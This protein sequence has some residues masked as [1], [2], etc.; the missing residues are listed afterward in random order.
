MDLD[1]KQN[2][3]A[4]IS[5][6][7]DLKNDK[8]FVIKSD[9]NKTYN[10]IAWA[11]GYDCV[12]VDHTGNPGTWWP[13]NVEKSSN[14]DALVKAFKEVGFEM[15]DDCT[16]EQDFDKVILYKKYNVGLNEDEWTHASRVL[17]NDV[18]YSKFG[19]QWDGTHSHGVLDNTTKSGERNSYG[20]PYAYMKR[21]KGFL[22][23]IPK[24]FVSVNVSGLNS[25]INQ[26]KD[27]ST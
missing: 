3:S 7:P 15:A 12:W 10:C 8:N 14:P 6:Y 5:V 9:C 20:K 13:E 27:K 23:H 11:M 1:T 22:F 18:E 16:V 25:L 4:L 24:G 19:P 17:S 21:H 26:Y 2:R